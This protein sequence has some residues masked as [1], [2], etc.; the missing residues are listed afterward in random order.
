MEEMKWDAAYDGNKAK[1]ILK[2]N[3]NGKKKG[4]HYTLNNS[5]LAELFNMDSVN[6]P[7]HRRLKN[8][9]NDSA[10]RSGPKMYRIELPESSSFSQYSYPEYQRPFSDDMPD[11]TSNDTSSL[12]ELLSS[13]SPDSY[14]SSPSSDEEFIIPVTL[15]QSSPY[16][17]YTFTPKRRNLTFKN[18]KTHRVFKR[19]KSSRRSSYSSRRRSSRS[20]R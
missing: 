1:I 18:H 4:Y 17:R 10:F 16:E 20:R 6:M 8:D 11:D 9:F 13:S 5:D 15:N 19:P 3:L 14:L 12:M 2:T 7:I